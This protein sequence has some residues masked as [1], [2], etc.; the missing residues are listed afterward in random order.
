REG[1]PCAIKR[2]P[3]PP[4]KEGKQML[5]RCEREVELL[6][7]VDSCPHV[8]T[9]WHLEVNDDYILLAM[10]RCSETLRDHIQRQPDLDWESR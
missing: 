3:M 10:E 6:R 5:Q 2:I 7:I 8:C 4:G 1:R 9:F